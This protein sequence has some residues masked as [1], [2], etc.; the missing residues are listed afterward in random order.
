MEAFE[1]ELQSAPDD[2]TIKNVVTDVAMGG[3]DEELFERKLSK[4][5]KK[6]AAKAKR[7]KRKKTSKEKNNSKEDNN[8]GDTTDDISKVLQSVKKD[9]NQDDETAAAVIINDGVNHAAADALAKSDGTVCTFSTSR[10]GI[11]ARSRDINVQNF[12][13]Q[14][15]GAVLL[16]HTAVILNHGNRYGLV[17]R[18]GTGKSTLLKAVS[19]RAVPVPDHIDIFILDQEVPA[20]DTQTALDMVMSV[21]KER[22]QLEQQAEELNDILTRL[23]E[24]QQQQQDVV[25]GDNSGGAEN[26][27]DDNNNNNTMSLDEQQEQVL[28]AV[29][30]VY[31]RLDALDAATAEVRARSILRGLGFTHE[32]QS[33]LTR[34]FSGGWRM[35][36]ALARALFLQP[37]CLLL[38]ELSFCLF[39]VCGSN[40]HSQACHDGMNL[41]GFRSTHTYLYSLLLLFFF[42]CVS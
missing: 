41:F 28:E 39:C 8:N 29:T 21:D 22:L 42:V 13:L 19:A 16:D 30:A 5:E 31:D 10:K 20:S 12:T 14:H 34:D 6:A 3:G 40:F 32:M 24:Q 25:A 15:R 27:G 17:G 2:T 38:D 18:N 33:K 36:V 35:R 37:M 4:E 26:G 9:T 7:D 11:D 23:S 1:R